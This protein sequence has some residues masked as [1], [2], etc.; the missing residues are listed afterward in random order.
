MIVVI[1]RPIERSPTINDYVY[2][3]TNIY[4]VIDNVNMTLYGIDIMTN[5]RN[6]LSNVNTIYPHLAIRY[7]RGTK[8]L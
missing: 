2:D 4:V 1:F 8:I 6:I 5:E 3:G 7:P